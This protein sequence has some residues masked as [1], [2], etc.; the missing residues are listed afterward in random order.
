[1]SNQNTTIDLE[2]GWL[3]HLQ[4]QFTLPYMSHLKSFLKN[5]K[6]SGKTIYPPGQ[7][8]F[9]AFNLTPFEQV[10]IVILGQDPYH[11]P[12]QAHGLSFS[13]KPGVA[14]PPSLINIYK[15]MQ[16]DIG[17]EQPRH[18]FLE[19]WAKQ[20]VLLL[21]TVLT[22]E[23]SQAGSHRKKGWEQFTDFAIQSLN[24][25]REHLVFILWGSFAQKKKAMIDESKHFIIESPHPSPLSSYRGFFGSRPFS[26]ANRYLVEHNIAPVDWQLN[27]NP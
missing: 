15:E 26:R 16:D 4:G 10:K 9:A 17:I 23:K 2:A 8:I 25:H 21:N 14:A 13:V 18:G 6:L 27:Q 12:G 1:M 7:E 11:G 19:Y 22:V 24:E 20:G 5:E 3:Q